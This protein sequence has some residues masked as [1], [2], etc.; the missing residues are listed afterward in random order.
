MNDNSTNIELLIRYLDGELPEEEAAVL[1]NEI[2]ANPLLG[3]VL[4]NIRAARRGVK[5]YGIHQQV[6]RVRREMKTGVR[7]ATGRVF[8]MR[9]MRVA[10]VFLLVVATASIYYYT[11]LTPERLYGN[12]FEAFPAVVNR[13][14]GDSLLN[15]YNRN[16]PAK[17][18]AVFGRLAS[19]EARDYLLAA[20]AWLLLGQPKPAIRALVELQAANARQKTQEYQDDAEYYLAMGYLADGQQA[21][22]IPIFEK[23]YRTPD[24]LYH[25]KVSG[26]FLWQLHTLH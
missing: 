21:K 6:G 14:G 10:A 5:R 2:E 9:I 20:N 7:P 23:I 26:W 18:V 15:A 16:D 17:V 12:N 19:P 11:R 4:E 3:E 1:Q 25:D 24:H 8:R 22:A 13:G